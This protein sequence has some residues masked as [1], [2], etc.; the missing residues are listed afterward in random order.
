MVCFCEGITSWDTR[1]Y[2]IIDIFIAWSQRTQG[3]KWVRGGYSDGKTTHV[4]MIVREVS[5]FF[6]C[7]CCY[8]NVT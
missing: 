8:A 7:G 6:P 2:H 5:I 3:E 1:L 4:C